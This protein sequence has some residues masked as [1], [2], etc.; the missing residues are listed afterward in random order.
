[1][2]KLAACFNKPANESNIHVIRDLTES[3]L[4]TFQRYFDEHRR[5]RERYSLLHIV[6]KN[7]KSIQAMIDDAQGPKGFVPGRDLDELNSRFMNYLSAVYSLREHLETALKRDFGRDSEHVVRYPQII[8]FLEQ[9]SFDYAFLQDFRNF[10]QHCGFPVGMVNI[11]ATESGPVVNVKFKRDV[12]LR[13]YK[14]WSKSQ[15]ET[16][17]ES[18]MDLLAITRAAHLIITKHFSG[19]IFLAYAGNLK[20]MEPVFANYHKEAADVWPASVA[21][22]VLSLSGSPQTGGTITMQDIPRDIYGELGLRRP[23]SQ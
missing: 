9:R 17:T 13:S 21:K 4:S 3:E 11:S 16:R 10:V 1:M 22:I 7:F 2:A 23:P 8:S 12:L 15:L 18:E 6:D 20:A 14:G 19:I 5:L